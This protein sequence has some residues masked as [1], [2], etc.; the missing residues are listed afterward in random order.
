MA[1]IINK[2]PDGN[3]RSPIL[4]WAWSVPR[5]T[6]NYNDVFRVN[7]YLYHNSILWQEI[8]ILPELPTHES[9]AYLLYTET[10]PETAQCFVFYDL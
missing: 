10:K 6:G 9:K 2:L 1:S 3:E 4:V 7:T 8:K 5:F